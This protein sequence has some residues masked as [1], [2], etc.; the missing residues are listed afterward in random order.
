MR[1]QRDINVQLNHIFTSN[2][3]SKHTCV[4]YFEKCGRPSDAGSARPA[5]AVAHTATDS[6]VNGLKV[7]DLV[8]EGKYVPCADGA[9]SSALR[10][11]TSFE[12][13][14]SRDDFT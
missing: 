5:C 13:R 12:F 2:I 4:K 1:H 8:P 10:C 9:D 3:L 6:T 7:E 14:I 11:C